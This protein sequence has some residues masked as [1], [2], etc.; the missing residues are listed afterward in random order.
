MFITQYKKAVC[1]LIINEE[2]LVLA[3]SRK[4]NKDIF[5][6]PGGKV[7]P[8]DQT[9]ESAAARELFEETGISA[10]GGTAVY[11]AMCYGSDGH[12]YITTTF[13]WRKLDG[14]PAQVVGEGDVAWIST[15]MMCQIGIKGYESFGRYN[16]NLFNHMDVYVPGLTKGIEHLSCKEYKGNIITR[17]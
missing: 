7:D 17:V 8:E 2:G 4:D 1:S 11:T 14:K 5:G 15:D 6:L 3:C 16:L 13:V 12:H 10:I 9:L